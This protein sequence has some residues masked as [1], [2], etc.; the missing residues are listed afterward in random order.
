M[1]AYDVINCITNN[2][3]EYLAQFW[4]FYRGDGL[5]FNSILYMRYEDLLKDCVDLTKTDRSTVHDWYPTEASIELKKG[6]YL[7]SRLIS[8]I[9]FGFDVFGSDPYFQIIIQEIIAI[10][11]TLCS[12]WWSLSFNF[13]IGRLH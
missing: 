8:E 10:D 11:G 12:I 2:S 9:I 6:V 7:S 4:K 13:N 1:Y 3:N 5:K